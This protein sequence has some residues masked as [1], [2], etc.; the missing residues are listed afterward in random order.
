MTCDMCGRTGR[1]FKA[2]VEGTEL[3]VCKSC[4]KYGK[5]VKPVRMDFRQKPKKKVEK[6]L[7]I[8]Q[9]EQVEELVSE[10][11]ANLIKKKREKLELTQEKLAKKINE[12]ESLIQKVESGHVRPSLRL[13]RKLQNFLKIKLVEEFKLKKKVLSRKQASGPLTIGDLITIKRK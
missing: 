6:K 9:K 3:N 7:E 5:V 8:V 11:F 13:A 2:M 10:D 1:L 4:S 12:K